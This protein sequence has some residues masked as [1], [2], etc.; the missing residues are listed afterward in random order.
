[1]SA[2]VKLPGWLGRRKRV[3]VVGW[4]KHGV[5]GEFFSPE[6]RN[7]GTAK[8]SRVYPEQVAWTG[9]CVPELVHAP[10]LPPIANRIFALEN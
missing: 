7:K 9:A 2:L 1:M 8:M 10:G 6:H 5:I 3:V 4:N